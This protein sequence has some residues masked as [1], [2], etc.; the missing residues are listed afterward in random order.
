[1]SSGKSL[2]GGG[3]ADRLRR[4]E[5]EVA[6]EQRR[7]PPT[8]HSASSARRTDSQPRSSPIPLRARATRRSYP[9]EEKA[10]VEG[11][12]GEHSAAVSRVGR[13]GPRGAARLKKRPNYRLLRAGLE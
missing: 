5:E 13:T 11:P 10:A 9:Q 2:P 1:M 8:R 12:D 6:R 7:V 4:N 3:N